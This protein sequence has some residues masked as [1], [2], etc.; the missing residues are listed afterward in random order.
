MLASNDMILL[1]FLALFLV[2]AFL[3]GWLIWPFVSIIIL[4]SVV[5][6]VCSPVY[7][8]LERWVGSALA[9]LITCTMV[10]IILFVPI[11]FFVGVL[12]KEAYNL[13][14]MGKDAVI[15]DQVR[16]LLQGSTII[17]R[18]N[19]FLL[20]IKIQ[21]T[22]EQINQGLSELGKFVGL[23]LYK[24]ASVIASNFFSF[25]IN[26]FFML[27]VTF[28]FLMDG[29]RLISFI[30][31]LS[32]LPTDQDEILIGKFR[33][34]AGAILIGNGLCGLVQGV[35][36][37]LIFALFGIDSPILWGVIMALLAFM[38]IV[39]IGAAFIPA[40]VYMVLKGHVATGIF[41]VVFYL[42]LSSAV[43]YLVKPKIVGRKVQM[44]TLLVFLSIMGGLKLFGIIGIIYG[45]LVVTAFLT[46]TDIYHASYQRLIEPP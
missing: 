10:F 6:G 38:P 28:F 43:E 11:V 42:A 17:E 45:P 3:V 9:A 46:L 31:D 20:P 5:T 34:M 22:G 29:R 30:I 13:Y 35:A 40:A 39:G 36:G 44:H 16:T 32:P 24:Q 8:W 14:L 21:I 27:L 4:A 15:S 33:D 18:V 7:R 23:F 1:F 2:S 12:S 26:F 19:H 41:F 37:G 25:L